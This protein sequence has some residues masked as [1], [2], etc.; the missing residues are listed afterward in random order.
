M[1]T[2]QWQLERLAVERQNEYLREAA[3]SRMLKLGQ[4]EEVGFAALLSRV[5][6]QMSALV[7]RVQRRGA[8][9]S[10]S[11]QRPTSDCVTC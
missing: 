11:I 9:V 6:R 3:V 2:P 10:A 8:A 1:Y 4:A 5:A 7:S